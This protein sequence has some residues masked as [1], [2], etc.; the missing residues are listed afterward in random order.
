MPNESINSV[1]YKEGIGFIAGGGLDYADPAISISANG[2]TG[3]QT[4]TI[5]MPPFDSFVG[6]IVNLNG[7]LLI[8]RG[9]GVH[10][11]LYSTNGTTW[12]VTEI[13]LG[14]KGF[15]YGNGVYVVGGQHGQAARSTN[16]AAWTVLPKETTTFDNGSQSQLY[17]NAVAYGNGR[18]VMGGGRGHT[19]W[20]TDGQT[21]TGVQ[22]NDS[23]SEV[24]F[25]GPSGFI[26]CMVFGADKFV[27]LGGM[28]GYDAKVAYST[29][30]V[31]WTQGGDPHLKA[32]SGSPSVEY[33]GGYFLA[34]DNAGNA[35]YSTDGITWTP[36][37]NTTFGTTPIKGIAYGIGMF[38][39]VGGEGKAA[40][41][42]P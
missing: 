33:G 16:I 40:Y 20:S 6:K 10:V 13:G 34:A 27:A 18:F 31:T 32:G 24:I 7:T 30:G 38:V 4:Q 42:R 41:A 36:I 22:G 5:H 17:I 23:V 35:S 26:D 12:T 29:D 8:T 2:V 25:D 1:A 11:G 14:T 9:S 21:W 15:A 19:A 3:W 28:D 39:M 37:A